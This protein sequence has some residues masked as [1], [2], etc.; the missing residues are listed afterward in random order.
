MEMKA[1][2]LSSCHQTDA[3][4]LFI[5]FFFF[6]AFCHNWKNTEADCGKNAGM[7]ALQILHLWYV[8]ISQV[9]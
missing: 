2:W 4:I 3:S 6:W 8:I 1:V 9:Y 5:F 7:Q